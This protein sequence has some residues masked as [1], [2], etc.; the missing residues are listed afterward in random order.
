M[1]VVVW[2]D[3]RECDEVGPSVAEVVLEKK[4]VFLRLQEISES[5]FVGVFLLE[6]IHWL[7]VLAT[8]IMLH[9]R[10]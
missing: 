3:F 4:A 5:V 7:W 6:L 10:M 9:C 1:D 2:V 8:G